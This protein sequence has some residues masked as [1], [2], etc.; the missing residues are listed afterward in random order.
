MATFQVKIRESLALLER[1]STALLTSA[2]AGT[3]EASFSAVIAMPGWVRLLE[4]VTAGLVYRLDRLAVGCT[5]LK[6]QTELKQSI[7]RAWGQKQK[8]L[9]ETA[10]AVA[11][12]YALDPEYMW[13]ARSGLDMVEQLLGVLADREAAMLGEGAFPRFAV[14]RITLYIK[15]LE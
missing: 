11:A 13:D 15:L 10:V 6:G 14:H 8:A 7:G 12:A 3:A 5:L 1:L 4:E 9:V 2:A